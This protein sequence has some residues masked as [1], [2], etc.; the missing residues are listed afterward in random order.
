MWFSDVVKKIF[1]QAERAERIV[2]IQ[3]DNA[4]AVGA[5]LGFFEEI[6]FI[7]A[8]FGRLWP[9]CGCLFIDIGAGQALQ[10]QPWLIC[11]RRGHV[12]WLG[13]RAE[14][15]VTCSACSWK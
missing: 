4:G 8:R 3:T 13:E 5:E 1:W 7:L 15:M 2:S 14:G 12:P 10:F 6:A 9:V 11:S